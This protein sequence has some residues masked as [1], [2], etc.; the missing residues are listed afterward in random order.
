MVPVRTAQHSAEVRGGDL[1]RQK[2]G[3][4]LTEETRVL[5]KLRPGM[6]YSAG[7]PELN[8]N[9]STVCIKQR[10]F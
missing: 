7:G 2:A 4:R 9:D 10:R 1:K 5:E 3:M 6:S 8:V